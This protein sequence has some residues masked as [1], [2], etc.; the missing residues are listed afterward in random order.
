MAKTTQLR[1][2]DRSKTNAASEFLGLGKLPPQA[3]DHEQSLLG[4]IMLETHALAKV[5]NIVRPEM[6]YKPEHQLIFNACRTLFSSG[7]A[8]DILSVTQF[9]RKSEAVEL[10]GGPGYIAQ[11]TGNILSSANIEVWAWVVHQAFIGREVIRV[12]AEGLGEAYEQS[13]TGAF[14]DLSERIASDLSNLS[15]VSSAR[16]IRLV[17]D[18]INGTIANIENRRNHPE[19]APGIPTGLKRIDRELGGWARTDLIV[20]AARPGM[21]KTSFLL[22]ACYAAAFGH[23]VLL[24][25]LEMSAEQ[26]NNRLLAFVSQINNQR[27]FKGDLNPEEWQEVQ[28]AANEIALR[29]IYIDD[30]PAQSISTIRAKARKMKMQHGIDLIGVDYIQIMTADDHI[31][32]RDTLL[33]VSQ[34]SGGLKAMAKELD[35]PVIALSQLSRDVDKRSG[36]RKPVLSDLR[37]SG[38]IEQDADIVAFIYRPEYYGL[39]EDRDGKPT[40]GVAWF[41]VA[42]F[43]NGDTADILLEFHGET[44]SFRG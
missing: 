29:N 39:T 38:T 33:T 2:G 37:D 42:K 24:F 15:D 6:F 16:G 28:D 22:Q 41:Q 13:N 17:G 1:K 40:K 21:G 32:A 26:L 18:T 25:S 9:L 3:L 10:A 44:T 7:Q 11:L 34:S 12:C 23:K 8:V 43:R 30:T 14:I 20:I 31:I 4:A 27:I 19:T 36:D 35:V 5:I